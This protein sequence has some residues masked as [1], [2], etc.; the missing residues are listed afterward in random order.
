LASAVGYSKGHFTAL[1]KAHTGRTPRRFQIDERLER[2]VDLLRRPDLPVGEVALRTG[3][4]DPLYFS[5][6]FRRRYGLAPGKWR[7]AHGTE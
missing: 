3:F 1:F 5:R 4:E 2:A 6:L 7:E